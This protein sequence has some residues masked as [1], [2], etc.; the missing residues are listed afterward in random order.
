[1]SYCTNC[2]SRESSV[3]PCLVNNHAYCVDHA[4]RCVLCK[5]YYCY[6]CVQEDCYYRGYEMEDL[7]VQVCERCVAPCSECDEIIVQRG[8]LCKSCRRK[9]LIQN[10]IIVDMS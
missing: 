1:M 6:A 4:E 5:E 8:S 9:D 3:H 7:P 2:D 10:R